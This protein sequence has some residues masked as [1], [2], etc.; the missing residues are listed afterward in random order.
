MPDRRRSKN[1]GGGIAPT[2]ISGPYR[3][4]AIERQRALGRRRRRKSSVGCP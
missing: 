3:G 1:S 4:Q 2:A